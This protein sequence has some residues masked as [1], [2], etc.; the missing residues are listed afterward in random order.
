MQIS[1]DFYCTVCLLWWPAAS[2]Q[3]PTTPIIIQNTAF[4]RPVPI[5]RDLLR[6]EHP[7]VVLITDL[8]FR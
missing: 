4:E 2:C 1:F 8:S 3:K 7:L 6:T 5:L